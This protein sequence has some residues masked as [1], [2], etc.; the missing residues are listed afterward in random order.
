[1]T[2]LAIMSDLHIDSN[3]FE[4]DELQTLVQV[5]RDQKIDYLHIAGDISNDFEGLSKPFLE[6]LT[7]DFEVTYNLGNHDML[8][9]SEEAIAE[10]DFQQHQIGQ[11]TLI[12]FAGWYDYSFNP[13]ISYK[14]N[15]RHKNLYWFD[16][17]LKRPAD[18]IML[19]K[20]SLEQLKDLVSSLSGPIIVAM[21][22]VPHS[23]YQTPYAKVDFLNSFLGSQSYHEV[24]KQ[25]QVQDVVFGH[26][27]WREEPH[28]FDGVTYHVRPLGYVREWQLVRDFF[29]LHPEIPYNRQQS[30]SKRFNAVKHLSEFQAY[31][32]QHLYKEFT[33]AMT[34]FDL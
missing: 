13:E 29:H 6:R 14:D 30:P 34:I 4:E 26:I 18:D 10:L 22:F 17:K 32:A 5:L 2:R 19:T 25:H 28:V 11:A 31:K 21:H 16:R 12:S 7:K 20:A 24:F 8:G 9:L 27:H 1:M 23:H 15:L 3:H 33:S